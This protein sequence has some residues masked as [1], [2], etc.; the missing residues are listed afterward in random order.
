MNSPVINKLLPYIKLQRN[1]ST[2]LYL[3]I[4]QGIV[5]AI[6]VKIVLRGEK[7][8]GTRLLSERLYIHRQTV[9]A[10]YDELAA[11]GWIEILPQ[12]GAYVTQQKIKAPHPPI[13]TKE[14]KEKQLPYQLYSNPVLDLSSNVLHS[15][16]FLTDGTPDYR[17]TDLKLLN[18]FLS[19]A[20]QS[21][22]LLNQL[23]KNIH[24]ENENLKNQLINLLL[25][26]KGIAVNAEKILVTGNHKISTLCILRTL[27][28]PNDIVVVTQPG[29]YFINMMLKDCGAKLYT[30]SLNEKGLDIEELK[31]ILAKENIRAFYIHTNTLYPTARTL[32][33]EQKKELIALAKTYG[34][35]IIEDDSGTDFIFDRQSPTSLIHH[36]DQHTVVY[37]NSLEGLLPPPYDMGYIVAPSSVIREL[38][39]VKNTLQSTSSPLIEHALSEYVKEGYFLRQAQRLTK[40]Y[41]RRRNQFSVLLDSY[42]DRIIDFNP[43]HMG[44][45]FWVEFKQKVPLLT[46]C[47][48]CERKG[49]TIPQHILYQDKYITAMRIGYGHLN[50]Q[51]AEKAIKIWSE[52]FYEVLYQ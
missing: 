37:L 12:R 32:S 10:A 8:P 35:A 6:Q 22:W 24:S 49:L 52:G 43:P 26:Q 25:I 42:F 15:S 47:R 44:L 3:Q 40:L 34:F 14:E 41:L 9:V 7:L 50:E 38:Q 33:E 45:A 28:K 31:S 5:K 13:I 19:A 17:T 39:K 36:D 30:V 20:S 48:N 16:L 1:D 29:H 11:Q 2:P 18:T 23:N 46:I 51:E 4:A 27:I 21:K